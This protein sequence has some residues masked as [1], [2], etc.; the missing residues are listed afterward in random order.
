MC[1]RCLSNAKLCSCRLPKPKP[2]SSTIA[3]RAMPARQAR[4]AFAQQKGA[5]LRHHV[6]ILGILLHGARLAL[7]VHEAHADAGRGRPFARAGRAQGVHVVDDASARPRPP[8][9]SPRAC[10]C[11]WRSPRREP[12]AMRSI[13]G[14]TRSRS[15][16]ASTRERAGARGL[17]AHVD[18]GCALG[19]H[20][21]GALD[22]RIDAGVA[23]A[24]GKGIGGHVQDA[25]DDRA[26]QIDGSMS[27]LPLHRMPGNADRR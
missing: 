6:M 18:D 16:A 14:T 9:P 17:A 23:A 20:L 26:R 19:D 7:H 3:S 4:R 25:H 10:W 1:A 24:V 27:A 2:G 5:H 13:T 22:G 12:A 21:R 15:T 11:R 8:P